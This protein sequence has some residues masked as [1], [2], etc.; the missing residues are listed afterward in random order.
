MRYN[1]FPRN[2]HELVQRV[3]REFNDIDWNKLKVEFEDDSDS[4]KWHELKTE[5]DFTLA[6]DTMNGQ[7][8]FLRITTDPNYLHSLNNPVVQQKRQTIQRISQNN[9]NANWRCQQCGRS[10]LSTER[11]CPL[12][13]FAKK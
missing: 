3:Q 11:V 13:S 5:A 9:A 1:E 10:N 8:L 7:G 12:C 2:I 6:V 4:L